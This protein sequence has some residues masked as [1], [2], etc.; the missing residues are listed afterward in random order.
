MPTFFYHKIY[1]TS[2]CLRTSLNQPTTT[3]RHDPCCLSNRSN[4]VGTVDH[5]DIMAQS[6]EDNTAAVVCAAE[7]VIYATWDCCSAMAL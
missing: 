7:K 1:L 2:S 3:R 6:R 4:L 5:F